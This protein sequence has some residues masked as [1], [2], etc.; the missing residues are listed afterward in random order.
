MALGVARTLYRKLSH[1][2]IHFFDLSRLSPNVDI[3]SL[4]H[5]Y[6]PHKNAASVRRIK[7]MVVDLTKSESEIRARFSKTTRNEISRAERDGVGFFAGGKEELDRFLSAFRGLQERKGIAA[8]PK[9]WYL[10]ND[11]VITGTEE[12]C[13]LYIVRNGIA[14]LLHSVS[15]ASK[16]NRLNHWWD[17]Q[18]FK[19]RGLQ[20]LDFGGWAANEA[21]EEKPELKAIADFKAGF[22]P[23]IR[24][25]YY[26][27]IPVSSIGR[28]TLRIRNL[29]A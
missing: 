2:E 10:L 6:E 21:E 12:S 24:P 29:Q 5:T 7:T 27:L 8:Y 16:A 13:H 23:E 28:L 17:I 19:D 25:A 1:Y 4:K 20:L 26:Q 9:S 11:I 18:L 14:L 15:H 22:G 3:V